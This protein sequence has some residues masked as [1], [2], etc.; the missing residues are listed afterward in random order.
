V[1]H[2]V[3]SPVTGIATNLNNGN[4]QKNTAQPDSNGGSSHDRWTHEEPDGH[5]ECSEFVP[6]GNDPRLQCHE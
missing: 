1:G 2:F 5:R 6:T 3:C 4:V